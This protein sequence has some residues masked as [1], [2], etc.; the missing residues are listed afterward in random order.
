MLIRDFIFAA[1]AL[2]KSPVFT[3]AAILTIALGIGASTAIFSVANA[4]LLRPL[5]YK[6]PDRLVFEISD[7]RKRNVQ[8]FPLSNCDFLDLRKGTESVFEDTAAVN[9]FNATVPREDGTAEQIHRAN[10]STNF[11]RT[12]GMKIALGRDFSHAD[13]T[14]QPTPPPGANGANAAPS[15]PNMVILSHE[16]WQRRFAGD[17]NVIGRGMPGARQGATQIVGVLSP[18]FE[19]LF[20]AKANVERLP[21]VFFAARIPYD[22]QNRNQV[23]HRVIARLRE[24]AS[25]LQAQA[26]ADRVTEETRKNFIISGTA[27]Y[28]V[29]VEPMHRHV[30]E[31]VR[32]AIVALMGAVIFL[33]LIA[34]ANVANLLLVRASLRERE[35]AVRT[36]LGGSWWR[37]VTQTLA[38]ASW[39]ALGGAAIGVGLAAF[40]IAQ[41]RDIAPANL[42]R[43]D[44]V[45]IDPVV[46]G[47]T[48]VASLIAAAIFGL[49]PA[50]RAARPDIAI[51]LRGSSRNVGLSGGGWMRNAVVVLEVALCFVLLVGSGLMFRS[52]QELHRVDPGFESKNMLEFGILGG[53]RG[54]QPEARAA[55]MRELM[56]KLRNI[57]GVQ[58]VTGS[59]PFPLTGN[60]SP[61]R[62][63]LEPALADPS[64]FMAVDF[65]FVL[66]G[67]FE[68]VHTPILAGRSFTEED[69][70]PNRDTVVVDTMLAAKAFP[71]QS[72]LG[73]RILIR[74]RGP[75]P[76]WVQIVGVAAHQR[77]TSLADPGREQIYLTDGYVGHG[78]I[79]R[80]AL[81]TAGDPSAVAAAARAAVMQQD[82]SMVVVEME[83]MDA[84]VEHARA[85][86]R[87][88][89]LLIGIFAVIA[90]ILAAVGL[91][92]VLSTMVRQRT[93]EIGVRVALGAAPSTIFSLIVGQGLRLS[94]AGV[95]VGLFAAYSLTSIMTS[96][97]VGVKPTDPL[98]FVAMVLLFL[99]IA[100]VSSWLPARRA[101][102]LDPT[103]ALRDE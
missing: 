79:G 9:T 67:Y 96:M 102:S 91:Y 100:A 17:V 23:Q 27:G 88:Q 101:A 48:A 45:R 59:F 4:V 43:L 61:I 8:D 97:L 44:G 15:L 37:L 35:L 80:I 71:G 39:L 92:G 76:E 54:Q 34:C 36:A 53:R 33:L 28:A 70:A 65:Q 69:N 7:L 50:V 40:G 1:R 52:F 68:T 41:L 6:N 2:R 63:G 89:L 64:R 16:F 38:E 55:Y 74:A 46:L 10:V 12:L 90:A 85:G 87:F 14:P 98:T 94:A 73:K 60:F 18:G 57:P 93:A 78:N 58:N 42:P 95:L 20:P 49:I 83:T 22:A 29:R 11:F 3:A 13:G 56:S 81:R 84:V 21:D 82:K 66:P 24:G 75:Q 62:W 25:I 19:L 86:T 72:A 5:P 103:R 77:V 31:E 51:V 47:F 32:P 99:S 26:A 30:V